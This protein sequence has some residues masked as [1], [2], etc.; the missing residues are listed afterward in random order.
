M[1]FHALWNKLSVWGKTTTGS[2]INT[3]RRGEREVAKR[4]KHCRPPGTTG[5]IAFSRWHHAVSSERHARA[6][7][8]CVSGKIHLTAQKRR[9]TRAAPRGEASHFCFPAAAAPVEMIKYTINLT[10]QL[11]LCDIHREIQHARAGQLF[12]GGREEK[13][14]YHHLV[15]YKWYWS[16]S[17]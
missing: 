15:S 11:G 12:G 10:R 2:I 14:K 5:E 9:A 7:G 13:K 6:V 8:H 17:N 3:N 4:R 1:T 16:P